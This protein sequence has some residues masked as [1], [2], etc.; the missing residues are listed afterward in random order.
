MQPFKLGSPSLAAINELEVVR[1]GDIKPADAKFVRF[2]HVSKL[3]EVATYGGHIEELDTKTGEMKKRWVEP[4]GRPIYKPEEYIEIL[5]PGDKDAVVQR[6]VRPNLDPYLYP[7]K[8]EAFRNGAQQVSG[9]PLEKWGALP[10][11]RVKEMEHFGVAT[12]EQLAAVPDSALQQMGR[13]IVTERQKA[14]NYLAAM[15]SEAPLS[16]LREKNEQL[17]ARIEALEKAAAERPKDSK[18]TK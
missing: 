6:P 3:D 5:T 2:F 8:Y 9:M 18:T 14:Q 11:E 12:V 4:A 17:M 16:D 15:S 1:R 13:G 7:E 10:P